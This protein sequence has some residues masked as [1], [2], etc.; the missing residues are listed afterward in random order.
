MMPR[1]TVQALHNRKSVALLND[2][3]LSELRQ[4]FRAVLPIRDERGY[5][6][7]AGIHGLPLPIYCRHGGQEGGHPLFLPL[8]RAYLYFFELALRDQVPGVS[9]PWWDWGTP[10]SSP[11][12]IPEAYAAERVDGEAN[13]LRSVEIPDTASPELIPQTMQQRRIRMP[14]NWDG[15]TFRN[16]GGPA[17][18]TLPTPEDVEQA[19]SA[20]NFLDFSD[21]L[22][23]L[24]GWVHVWIGGTTAEVPWAAYDPLFWAHH[25]MV[26]RLWRIWQLGNPEANIDR[27]LLRQALPPFNMTVEET[28]DVTALGYEYAST[29]AH[30]PGG[31]S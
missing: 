19:L 2:D 8:H 30:V 18:P 16:T 11:S 4:A 29:T 10:A 25:S 15:S 7:H 3:Q 12:E 17:A 6:H 9:V 20:P 1:T 13:P 31:G 26:D 14:E 28:L 5:Y 24:H 23:N 27:A 21:R 22:E